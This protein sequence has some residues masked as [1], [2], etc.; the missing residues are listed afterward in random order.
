[1]FEEKLPTELT[2]DDLH[3]AIRATVRRRKGYV[4]PDSPWADPA[5]VIKLRELWA[6]GWSAGKIAAVLG[7]TRNA[8][9]GRVH[10]TRLQQRPTVEFIPHTTSR[11]VRKAH[12]PIKP[13]GEP[14]PRGPHLVWSRPELT[15]TEPDPYT[16]IPLMATTSRFQCRYIVDGEKSTSLVCGAPTETGMSWCPHH[17]KRISGQPRPNDSTSGGAYAARILTGLA[18]R[19][20][21][22]SS[23]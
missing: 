20:L 21:S 17:L 8:I 9:I 3:E 7:V 14:K 16:V 15:E 2:V 18:F 6:A 10:R 22:G 5:K 12:Y 19:S 4:P 23:R 13:R 11:G 1:M